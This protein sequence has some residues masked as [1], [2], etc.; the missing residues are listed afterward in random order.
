MTKKQSVSSISRIGENTRIAYRTCRL[1][2]LDSHGGKGGSYFS[3]LE[4]KK[5]CRFFVCSRTRGLFAPLFWFP[6]NGSYGL[7]LVGAQRG[8]GISRFN[9]GRP[10]R[11]TASALLRVTTTIYDPSCFAKELTFQF[12]RSAFFSAD[13]LA[14]SSHV[15]RRFEHCIERR[16][17]WTRGGRDNRACRR[18]FFIFRRVIAIRSL[19]L[20]TRET[21]YIH[22]PASFDRF[23]PR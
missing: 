17:S 4:P 9:S 19:K 20:R 15:N 6:L 23:S 1:V 13:I 8:V 18:R 11:S 5:Q 3:M 14:F 7:L 12:E 16:E 22:R 10:A 2:R 21:F